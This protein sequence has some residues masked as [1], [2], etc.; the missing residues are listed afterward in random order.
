MTREPLPSRPP[1]LFVSAAEPSGDLHAA[2][3]V[4]AL[5]RERPGLEIAAFGGPRLA[6]AGV[7]VELELTSTASIGLGFLGNLGRYFRVLADF[8]RRL[9]ERRPD[10]VLLVDSP[11]LHFLFARLARWRGIPIIY[12]VCPQIWA[13]APWRRRRV[14]RLTDLLL[15]ILPFEVQLLAEWG[16]PAKGVGHPLGD[17]LSGYVPEDGARLRS[18]LGIGSGERVLGVFPGSRAREVRDLSAIFLA[19]AAAATG[20]RG[21]VRVV[22]SCFRPSYRQAITDAAHAAGIE[23]AIHEGDARHLMIACNTA[24]V[25]SGTASLELAYFT[26]PMFVLYRTGWWQR[27]FFAVYSVT[28]W[29]AL[30]NLLGAAFTGGDETVPEELFVGAPRDEAV[31]ILESLL[32][33]EEERARIQK[34]LEQVRR[35]SL[36][37]GGIVEA[38]RAID[39]FLTARLERAGGPEGAVGPRLR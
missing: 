9:C 18:A 20:H 29:I 8:D 16:V 28:P 35:Y 13:W 32:Y 38:A 26:R 10:A 17:E 33:D 22:V 25:A 4:E 23:V 21:G 27:A 31:S 34:T 2:H 37:P 39:T 19:L 36:R 11:G 5:R 7:E 1:H 14:A 24:L 12:Y 6:A 30:P 3:I 15:A